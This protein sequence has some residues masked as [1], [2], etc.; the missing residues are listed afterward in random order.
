MRE[1]EAC[2]LLLSLTLVSMS[3]KYPRDRSLSS[4]IYLISNAH[5]QSNQCKWTKVQAAKQTVRKST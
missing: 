3:P 2:V 4:V 5:T 1:K